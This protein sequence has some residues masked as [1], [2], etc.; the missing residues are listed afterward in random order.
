MLGRLSAHAASAAARSVSRCTVSPLVSRSALLHCSRSALA[1]V[2][3]VVPKMGDSITEGTV[4]KFPK[5]VGAAVAVDDV[6]A[7]LE[8]DK[9]RR[10]QD[11]DAY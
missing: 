11:V 7:V 3:V 8:T 5:G 9:V 1:D 4:L 2:V 6:L 10:G